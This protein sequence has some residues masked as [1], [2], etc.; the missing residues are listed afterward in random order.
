MIISSPSVIEG[1]CYKDERG[2]LRYNNSFDASQVK[3]LYLIQNSDSN[4]VRG[5]QGHKIEQRWFIAVNG[6]FEISTIQ[7]DDWDS[8]SVNLSAQKFILGQESFNV[9]HVPAGYITAIRSLVAGSTLLVMSDHLLGET[10][11][12]YRF[13]LNYFTVNSSK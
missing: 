6:A 1:A 8:P 4:P 10:K 12:E 5:W 3:R 7:V 2:E 9:L 13:P 11:D